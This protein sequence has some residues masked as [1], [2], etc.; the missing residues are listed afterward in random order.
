MTQRRIV[1]TSVMLAAWM[2]SCSGPRPGEMTPPEIRA[3]AT[4]SA[5]E[6]EIGELH[7]H[8]LKRLQAYFDMYAAQPDRAIYE[9]QVERM[10]AR[11]VDSALRVPRP[12]PIVYERTP[13]LEVRRAERVSM[14]RYR[15]RRV[16]MVESATRWQNV[17]P[18]NVAGRVSALAVDPD[19]ASTVYRGTA[20][21]GVWKTTDG[22]TT[23]TALT[24]DLGNL[25]IGAIAVT[26]SN[27]LVVYVGTGE[28]ALGIDGID[29]IGILKSSDGG[30]SWS[31]PI[32][33]PGTRVFALS[34]HPTNDAELLAATMAGV[35]RSTDG[36]ATW[37]T[38]ISKF[39]ATD[40][41][42]KPGNPKVVLATV[43]DVNG[44]NPSWNGFVYRSHDAG[45]TWSPVGAP[46]TAPFDV[47]TGRLSIAFAPSS[48][49]TAYLLAASASGDTQ[50]CPHDEV[51]QTGF[52]KSTDAGLT[53]KFLGNPV[54]GR[55]G[56]FQSIL[57]GQGWYANVIRVDESDASTV[58]AGGL[59]LWQSKDGGSSWQQV[60]HWEVDP[61]A[62]NYVHADIH[63]LVWAG[64][65][66]LIGNDG[67]V[68]R[69]ENG[70]HGFTTLNQGI[71]T[72]QYYSVGMTR[73]RT[74]LIVGGAQDNGTN[75]RRGSTREYFERIGGDGFAVAVD[76]DDPRRI[77]GTLYL[78]RIFR[79]TD[80][81]KTFS[82]VT[83]TYCRDERTPFIS[84]LTMDPA[85][86]AVLYTGTNL[87]WKTED[88][89]KT[90][91]KTSTTDLGDGSGLGYLTNIAVAPS[92][93]KTI[94]TTTG[95]GTVSK[96]T[97]GGR[98][99]TKLGGLPMG[100]AS[101][102]EFDPID[103][104]TFYVAY[105]R[106]SGGLLYKTTDGGVSFTNVHGGSLPDFPV[107]V[108][109]ANPKNRKALFAGTDV[110]LYQST[111]G[112]AQWSRVAAGLPQ[113]S[114]WDVEFTDDGKFVRVATH[115]RGFYEI[116]LA[117]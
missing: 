70:G 35:Q 47:D 77:Y 48:P 95:S 23:W 75:I 29:G 107:H 45:V 41:V 71:P 46:G 34:V 82:E 108:I 85:H 38:V 76:P 90:W 113:V 3:E 11:P 92:N 87:L 32:A 69:T 37:Q 52:Y 109:R 64:H 17:G 116:A 114:I 88:G 4:E 94:V 26:P 7:L 106:S 101:H 39:A 49:S 99:W 36:G 51:D 21:G 9:A 91:N 66:L 40:V 83:A 96:S 73:T 56:D 6:K 65:V 74:D 1:A 8:A 84:P 80:G 112:G 78:S 42:R 5:R 28:G 19:N 98:T 13:A 43:W 18:T 55:C 72:R 25:S 30:T 22:G 86:P 79:S 27:P 67:G 58:F 33:I 81:G 102:A 54:S 10:A 50:N 104:R 12:L 89:G 57:S 60:S 111:D 103:A 100:Y 62:S 117:P 20:G 63:A 2:I 31:G 110:G 105:T 97:D 68:S 16:E 15:A 93:T 24:D 115:G 53:W 14:A 44:Q 59:D 61:S